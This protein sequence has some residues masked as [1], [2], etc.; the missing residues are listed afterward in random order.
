MATDIIQRTELKSLDVVPAG[1]DLYG[2]DIDSREPYTCVI[3]SDD[4]GIE[5]VVSLVLEHLE[6]YA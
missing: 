5:E 3:D 1:P 2:I 6:G 4:L